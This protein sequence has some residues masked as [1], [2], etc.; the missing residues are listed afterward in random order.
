MSFH[1][2]R[3]IYGGETR[4]KGGPPFGEPRGARG[5]IFLYFLRLD[6]PQLVYE[7]L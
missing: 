1:N 7:M 2:E 6:K 5:F 3:G 4:S